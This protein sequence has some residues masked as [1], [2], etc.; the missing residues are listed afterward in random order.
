MASCG[1][2]PSVWVCRD[3]RGASWS[4][5]SAALSAVLG[6][7]YALMQ[8]DLKRLL[9]YHSIEN[10]GIILLGLG[11]G[12]MALADGQPALAAVGVAA[13]LYHVLEPRR[14]Q[15][16]A[17][18]RRRQRGHGDRHAAD[19]GVRRAAA[20]DAVDRRCSS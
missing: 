8:H 3:C 18:P 17:V 2:A 16:A 11:A 12:M 20:A 9:A 13:G 5:W 10:I 14:V 6:V 19:R 4:S 7:L 1:S 15:G